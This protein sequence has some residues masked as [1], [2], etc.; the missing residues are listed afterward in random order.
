MKRIGVFLFSLLVLTSCLSR[1]RAPLGGYGP[2]WEL[3]CTINGESFYYSGDRP[4]FDWTFGARP[5]DLAYSKFWVSIDSLAE[6][7][8]ILCDDFRSGKYWPIAQFPFNSRSDTSFFVE[9][10][11]YSPCHIDSYNW[12]IMDR[13][14]DYDYVSGGWFRFQLGDGNDILFKTDFYIVLSSYYPDAS[15][16]IHLSGELIMHKRYYI[17]EYND[18]LGHTTIGEKPLIPIKKTTTNNNMY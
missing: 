13:G 17:E 12:S 10:K 18:W 15:D 8:S 4:R 9:G 16:T 6:F 3:N 14:F 7:N 2:A 11:Y 1:Y 5:D